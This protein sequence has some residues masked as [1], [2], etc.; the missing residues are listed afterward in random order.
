ML[1][2]NLDASAPITILSTLSVTGICDA[3]TGTADDPGTK[4]RLVISKYFF[5]GTGGDTLPIP[6][7]TGEF[8]LSPSDDQI[9]F[10][11][12]ALKNV[13]LDR[14]F[15]IRFPRSLALSGD[16]LFIAEGEHILKVED[17]T[18]DGSAFSVIAP[19][20]GGFSFDTA[21]VSILP[22]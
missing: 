22:P 18:E 13:F 3:F 16:S 9:L 21:E 7:D 4:E 12:G 11:N 1:L 5:T 14:N 2:K 15:G 8:R 17:S 19:V 10:V 6:Y 20:L